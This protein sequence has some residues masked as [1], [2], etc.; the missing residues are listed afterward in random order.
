MDKKLLATNGVFAVFKPAGETSAKTVERV[1]NG[2]IRSAL[3][4]LAAQKHAFK[5]LAKKIK[6]G[7][8]G[9]LDPMATGVLVIGLNGGCRRLS[10]FLSG[11]KAYRAEA[12]FGEHFD[13]LDCTGKM[14]VSDDSWRT[15]GALEKVPMILSKFIGEAVMQRPP[16]FSA[17]HIN[18]VRA[19]ELARNSS[20]EAVEGSEEGDM[21]K[22]PFDMPARPVAIYDLK[23]RVLDAESGKFELEVE[24]GGGCYI[25]S[26]IR[27]IAEAV[28]SVA[29]MTALERTK[30]GLFTAEMCIPAADVDR[31]DVISEAIER[32]EKLK[33]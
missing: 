9:T 24:C 7:H 4:P 33:E 32:A 31:L 19:H 1:K 11:R 20:K 5:N 17:L 25:R 18:G 13:T 21:K 10:E 28:D 26:I 23:Y 12:R 8:G 2:L 16:A 22:E 14:V 3:G 30:Q 29:T 15:N 27:D 6:V